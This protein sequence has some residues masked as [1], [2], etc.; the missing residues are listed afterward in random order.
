MQEIFKEILEKHSSKI[1]PTDA[2][3]NQFMSDYLSVLVLKLIGLTPN[4]TPEDD[5]KIRG[6]I[7]TDQ[8]LDAV[9]NILQSKFESKESWNKFVEDQAGPLMDQFI[10]TLEK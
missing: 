10:E 1:Q 9:L 4:V 3:I 6:L 8:N 5:E 2:V 7:N